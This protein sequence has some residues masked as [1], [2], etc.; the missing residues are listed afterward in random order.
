MN[1]TSSSCSAVK[2]AVATADHHV[3]VL[4]PSAPGVR[5]SDERRAHV[6]LMDLK[7]RARIDDE[8]EI[9]ELKLSLAEGNA[10]LSRWA[11]TAARLLVG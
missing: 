6:K 11:S 9:Q 2:P 7:E 1:N 8:T 4:Q 5:Y 10:I 3:A